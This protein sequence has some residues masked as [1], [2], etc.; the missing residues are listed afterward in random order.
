VSISIVIPGPPCAQGRGCAVR[1]GA[2]IRVIDPAKS[3]AWKGAAQ[4]HMAEALR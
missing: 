2:G 3:R 4:V 1:I